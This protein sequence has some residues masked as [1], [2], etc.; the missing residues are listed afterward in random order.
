MTNLQRLRAQ[1]VADA[2]RRL[3]QPV[4]RAVL[5]RPIIYPTACAVAKALGN[6]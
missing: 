5:T 3:A 6:G 2:L 1:Q 4:Q